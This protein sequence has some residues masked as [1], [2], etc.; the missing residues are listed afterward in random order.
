MAAK[1]ERQPS[2]ATTG[3]FQAYPVIPPA[4]TS[5]TQQA[6]AQSGN[7]GSDD[8]VLTDILKLYLPNPLPTALDKSLHD[9]ARTCLDPGT[10][11]LMVDCEISH[12][13][14]HSLNTFGEANTI[15]PLRTSE[16]WRGLKDIQTKNG[17]VARGYDGCSEAGK[18]NLRI[19]QFALAHLWSPSCASVSCPAA[20]S[21]GAAI[22]LSK[23]LAL[24]SNPSTPGQDP[25]VLRGVLQAVYNRLVSFGPDYAWTSGQWMTE[26]PGGS[27][28]S[29]TET[30]ARLASTEELS[31]EK[32]TFGKEDADGVGMPLGPYLIDG[33][34]WFS[35]ATDA[36]MVVLLAQTK[37]GLSAFY[38]PMKRAKI[39][40][41]STRV[42]VMNGV[43]ISRLKNKMGTKGLPTAELEIKGMRGW[44]IGEEGRGVKGISA[45]LNATRL[46]TA[47][48][49]VGSWGRG[50]AVARA[51]AKVR[52]IKGE[53]VLA[54]NRQHVKWIAGEIVKYRACAHLAFLGVA[55]LGIAESG[56]EVAAKGTNAGS[57]MPK[58]KKEAE[59]LLRV[60]TPV[61]KAQCSLWSTLGLR[62]CMESLG[63]VGY[64]ENVEDGGVMNIARML[65][66]S[67]VNSVWEGTTNILAEDFVR[68]TKG[69]AGEQ[70]VACLD[71][72][73]VRM[74]GT[75]VAFFEENAH[76]VQ[77]RWGA[78]KAWLAST[79]TE[80]VLYQ[81]RE[82]LQQVQELI[83]SL[84]LMIQAGNT[85]DSLDRTIADRW[86]RSRFGQGREL[87]HKGSLEVES[88]NDR[89]IFLGTPTAGT[90]GMRSKL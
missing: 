26:R 4:Y 18:Y 21:D 3:F 71:R 83:C 49:A 14:L 85:G 41:D 82:V 6:S 23:H 51:Y 20:M 15:N 1:L 22:L 12:P 88:E 10:L 7:A 45:I 58:D 44:L 31:A 47:S 39:M 72:L 40:P 34:K 67:A 78:L 37:K 79:A 86:I 42:A 52:K 66:D 62:E 80:K 70:A 35:S 33:F 63:G 8:T 54:E 36:D 90:Q 25:K 28:V 56:W 46:W 53:Q 65:R 50:L 60:L 77:W 75:V 61:M 64:C 43:R 9:F 73:I 32:V 19:H 27:D 11:R 84:L 89:R 48:G 13:T 57:W 2:S 76:L 38:A 87:L 24:S 55:L 59:A 69:R 68:V 16:G 81:G 29:R 17:I 74:V 30:L 5:Q